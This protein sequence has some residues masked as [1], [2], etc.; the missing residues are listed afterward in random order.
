MSIQPVVS[1]NIEG[2]PSEFTK[3]WKLCN[4]PIETSKVKTVNKVNAMVAINH[5]ISCSF[6]HRSS[7][8]LPVRGSVRA[9]NPQDTR[10][11]PKNNV[12]QKLPDNWAVVIG[13][14]F[15]D[16]GTEKE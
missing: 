2:F 9:Q 4:K 8:P 5:R 16:M 3:A 15:D 6:S 14:D 7:R 13:N 10:Y 12:W 1:R 11:M